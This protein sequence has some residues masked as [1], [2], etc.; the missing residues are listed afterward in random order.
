MKAMNLFFG[1]ILMLVVVA[2][3]NP[4]AGNLNNVRFPS[5]IIAPVHYGESVYYF[6]A[7][8]AKFGNSLVEFIR[9]NP[10]LE[11]TAI[12]GDGAHVYGVDQGYWVITEKK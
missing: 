3:C 4:D 2:G 5:E 1:F 9:E 6:A 7:T 12:A 11:I 10:D 8:E